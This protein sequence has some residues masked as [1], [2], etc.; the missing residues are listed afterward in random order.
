MR[1]LTKNEIIVTDAAKAYFAGILAGKPAMRLAIV[2]GKGCGGNEYD[3]KPLE[4]LDTSSPDLA[5]PLT[6]E[7]KLVV[8]ATDF[9]KLFGSRIDYIT[10]NLGN[11]R[12]DISNPN[13]TGR[14]G[15]GQSAI[16]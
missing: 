14:C 4:T 11:S 5:V 3:L 12:V 6:G 10:D 9:L 2:S 8:A 7:Q 15:C 1:D 16:F 13:E